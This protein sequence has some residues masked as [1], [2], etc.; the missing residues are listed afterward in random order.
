MGFTERYIIELGST[1]EAL[2]AA[3]LGKT[4]YGRYEKK[5][6]SE[7]GEDFVARMAAAVTNMVLRGC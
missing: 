1:T 2:T 4:L 7:H 6:G 5:S 3:V